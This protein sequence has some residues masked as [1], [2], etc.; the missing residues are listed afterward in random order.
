M[1]EYEALRDVAAAFAQKIQLIERFDTF[2]DH[3]LVER[4]RHVNDRGRKG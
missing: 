4:V 3:L 1:R 2:R